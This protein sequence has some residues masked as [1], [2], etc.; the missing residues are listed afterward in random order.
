[1]NGFYVDFNSSRDNDEGIPI[2]RIMTACQCFPVLGNVES[3]HK[4][5]RKTFGKT[6]SGYGNY[7][8][9]IV[10]TLTPV[11]CY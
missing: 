1:M 6:I 4:S 9:V 3:T 2:Y 10:T 5:L 11:V 7:S 8:S